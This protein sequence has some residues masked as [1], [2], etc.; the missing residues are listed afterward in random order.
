[1]LVEF[2]RKASQADRFAGAYRR[3]RTGRVR[4]ADR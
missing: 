2:D 4:S 1:M 3:F